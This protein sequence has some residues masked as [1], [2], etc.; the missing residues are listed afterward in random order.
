VANADES[1]IFREIFYSVRG[2]FALKKREK[3]CIMV[4]GRGEKTFFPPGE[5]VQPKKK[6]RIG[7]FEKRSVLSFFRTSQCATM[8]L[9]KTKEMQT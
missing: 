9:S 6:K 4:S 8:W 3:S 7:F 5:E 2:G 1:P